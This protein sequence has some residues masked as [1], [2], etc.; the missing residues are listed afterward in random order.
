MGN[1]STDESA[2]SWDKSAGDRDGVITAGETQLVTVGIAFSRADVV[3]VHKKRT[4]A[5]ED[6]VVRQGGFQGYQC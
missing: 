5:L 6:V 4:V 1:S 3:D 2:E